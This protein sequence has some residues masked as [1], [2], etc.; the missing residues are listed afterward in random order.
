MQKLTENLLLKQEQNCMKFDTDKI[1]LIHFHSK[2]NFDL[3]NE[4]YSI[5]VEETIFQ[6][7]KVIKYLEI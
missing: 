4:K 7:K 5:K 2:R 6:S 1:K 3:E